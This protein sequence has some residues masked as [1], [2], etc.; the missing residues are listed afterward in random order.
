MRAKINFELPINQEMARAIAKQLAMDPKDLTPD[1]VQMYVIQSIGTHL[2]DITTRKN[3]RTMSTNER[4]RLVYHF[5]KNS[6]SQG[7]TPIVGASDSELMKAFR[8]DTSVP[9]IRWARYSLT[10]HGFLRE[11]GKRGS[12]KFWVITDKDV[13]TW[14][15]E[16]AGIREDFTALKTQQAIE[17]EV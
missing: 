6:R 9:A 5:C 16:D 15:R 3:V 4:M 13:P 8:S 10:Q 1:Q 2:R 12:G 7:G 17:C 11:G 14:L